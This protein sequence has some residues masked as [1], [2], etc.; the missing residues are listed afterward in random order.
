MSMADNLK[1]AAR[2]NPAWKPAA[3]YRIATNEAGEGVAD[4]NG[5][6]LFD[7][8]EETFGR[9]A[10]D[11]DSRTFVD[12]TPYQGHAV[13]RVISGAEPDPMA[14]IELGET[15]YQVQQVIAADAMGATVRYRARAMTA[16]LP[17]IRTGP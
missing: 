1:R 6:F 8:V 9:L 17:I 15:F 10:Y 16:P 4:A 14:M 3:I 13:I 11:T 12:E 5:T 7:L 2:F